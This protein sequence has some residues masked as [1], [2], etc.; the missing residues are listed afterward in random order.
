MDWHKKTVGRLA[1]EMACQFLQ[2]KGLQLLTMNYHC[3]QGEIDLIMQHES[4]IV[5]VEVRKRSR[6]DYGNALDSVNPTKIRKIIKAATHFLQKQN[7]LY[8]VHSRFDVIAIHPIN[9]R[10]QIEWV[11]NAFS[12][13]N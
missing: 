2:A 9:G 10:M 7:S 11:K 13:G 4:E 1:E 6:T 12:V 5:F 8:K 3:F